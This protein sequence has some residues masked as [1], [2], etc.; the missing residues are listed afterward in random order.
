MQFVQN[1]TE[2]RKEKFT[3]QQLAFLVVK[4]FG[5][6][7]AMAGV[8]FFLTSFIHALI[9][10]ANFLDLATGFFM[11]AGGHQLQKL[12]DKL[13]ERHMLQT[14][15]FNVEIKQLTTRIVIISVIVA[16]ILFI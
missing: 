12:G 10:Q 14:T 15:Y 7:G 1:E 3:I 8:L 11:L 5:H 4:G 2:I 16:A 9:G 13:D 6:L